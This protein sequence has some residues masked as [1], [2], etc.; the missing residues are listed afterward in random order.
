MTTSKALARIAALGLIACLIPGL[1]AEGFAA[2]GIASWYGAD[3]HGRRTANGETFDRFQFSAAHRSLPFGTLLLVTLESSGKRVVVRVNDRGPFIEGRIIDL[4][5]AAAKA[6]GLDAQGLG[7]VALEELKD[8]PV[9]PLS[10]AAARP[11]QAA[12][13]GAAMPSPAAAP[14]PAENSPPAARA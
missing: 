2:K 6:I 12:V 4:S 14:P 13:V 10:G 1:A 9:G 7:R 3:F 5:E 8:F 11:G